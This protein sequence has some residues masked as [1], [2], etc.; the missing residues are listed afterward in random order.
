MNVST[1]A[2]ADDVALEVAKVILDSAFAAIAERGRFHLVLS[3]GR[4]PE[5]AYRHLSVMATERNVDWS[6][7]EI[8][9]GDERMVPRDSPD[10]NFAMAQRSWLSQVSL[11]T[12]N[13]HGYDTGLPA[14]SDTAADFSKSLKAQSGLPVNDGY[15]VFDLILLGLGDDGH[16]ASLFPGHIEALESTK[17][18]VGTTPGTLPPPVDRVTFT[19][20]VLNHARLVLF[21]VAGESKATAVK[22]I[23]EDAPAIVDAPASGVR[24][25]VRWLLDNAAVSRLSVIPV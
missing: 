15:P 16:T 12:E 5:A 13:I 24:G 17:L 14:A 22:H 23:F 8:Y 1:F 6:K 4:T 7:V 9:W 2:S 10:S 25:N 18:V 20:P 3:G 21:I 11:P 19:F